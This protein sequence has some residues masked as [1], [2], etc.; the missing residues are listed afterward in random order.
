[1]EGR[2]EGGGG[3]RKEAEGGGGTNTRRDGERD[4]MREGRVYVPGGL[5][6]TSGLWWRESRSMNLIWMSRVNSSSVA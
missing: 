1:M 6:A 3:R 5:V 4:G 2:T